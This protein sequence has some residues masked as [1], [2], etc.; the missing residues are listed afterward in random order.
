MLFK[1]SFLP[2][3]T[4]K[5]VVLADTR[6][7]KCKQKHTS[8]TSATPLKALKFLLQGP[9]G[10]LTKQYCRKCPRLCACGT[11]PSLHCGSAFMVIDL[12]VSFSELSCR[13]VRKA[14]MLCSRCKRTRFSE[15]QQAFSDQ[16][17][18]RRRSLE[19]LTRE[20]LARLF[21]VQFGV[22]DRCHRVANFSVE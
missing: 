6:L 9:F 4:S 21:L 7:A 1:S 16:N 10:C 5:V 14:L 15:G 3:V 17:F 20:T 2:L 22:V 13:L 19:T 12:I 11:K 18:G 8:C